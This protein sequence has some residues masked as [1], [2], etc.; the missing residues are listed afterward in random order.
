MGAISA[1]AQ[2][3]YHKGYLPLLPG[4]A[5]APFNDLGAV[6]AAVDDET[7]A[8]MLEV[9]QGEGGINV[10]T[11]EFV[12]G[13]RALC[14]E[15]GLLMIVD[16]VSTGIGRTGQWF[17]YQHYGVEPDIMT[18]A[19]AFGSGM[20]IGAMVAKGEVAESLAP[21]THASTFGGSPLACSAALATLKV[22]EDGNLLAACNETGEHV[23]ARFEQM[24][25]DYGI[26]R[27][28]RGRGCMWGLELTRPGAAV[29]QRCLERRV[30]VNCTHETVMRVYP[31]LN[32]PRELLDEGLDVLEEALADADA[33]KI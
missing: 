16:E 4:F 24:A 1:T 14:D 27:E 20:P 6:R 17:G 25:G 18:L 19:K 12:R 10:G 33:G 32:V 13:V 30:R 9:I 15:A 2:D 21:G 26:V 22:I 7:C 29:F 31:A 3:K 28:V 8:V 23:R 5:Y 11:D